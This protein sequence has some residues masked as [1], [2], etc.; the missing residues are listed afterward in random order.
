MGCGPCDARALIDKAKVA[1]AAGQTTS[2]PLRPSG[3]EVLLGKKT[4][5]AESTPPPATQQADEQ[6]QPEGANGDVAAEA[7]KT[8]RKV[9]VTNTTEV[10]TKDEQP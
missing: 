6:L 8:R 9:S 1:A 3:L 2:L 4:L 5:G 10:A 7:K